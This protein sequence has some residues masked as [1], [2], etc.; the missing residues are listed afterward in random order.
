MIRVNFYGLKVRIEDLI[1]WGAVDRRPAGLDVGSEAY[2]GLILN[3]YL[4]ANMTACD[5][6]VLSV[7]LLGSISI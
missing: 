6:V 4:G 5:G 2:Q 1:A 7:K 3:H